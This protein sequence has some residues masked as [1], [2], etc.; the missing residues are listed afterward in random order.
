METPPLQKLHK[1]AHC[2]HS[3]GGN[4]VFSVKGAGIPEKEMLS[5]Q[6]WRNAQSVN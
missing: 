6:T 3:G 5:T 2:P 4:C 1:W